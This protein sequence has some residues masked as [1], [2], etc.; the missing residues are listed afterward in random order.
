LP[1]SDRYAALF[2]VALSFFVCQQATVIGVGSLRRPGPGLMAFGAGAGVGLLAFAVLIRSLLSKLKPVESAQV[3]GN[4]RSG[5]FF[6]ICTSL[7]VY[8]ALVNALGFILS[9][10]LFVFFLFQTAQAEKWWH[11]LV[12]AALITAGNYL[13]FVVWLGIHLPSAFW[14]R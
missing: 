5:K 13:V 10:F 7:F 4:I 3:G 8:A 9:T 12:K 1:R 6:L 14:A 2:F 11:S